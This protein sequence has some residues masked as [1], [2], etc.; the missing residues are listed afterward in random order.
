MRRRAADRLAVDDRS[1]LGKAVPRTLS[2]IA[3]VFARGTA[4]VELVQDR[5]DPLVPPPHELPVVQ[6]RPN[7][8]GGLKQTPER[9]GRP[10]NLHAPPLLLAIG[11]PPIRLEVQERPTRLDQV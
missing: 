8:S 11:A 5:H 1:S 9:L 4:T 6:V 7:R 3:T 10:R 2:I